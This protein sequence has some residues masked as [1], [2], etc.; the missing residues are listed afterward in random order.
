MTQVS[1]KALAGK[2]GVFGGPHA[3][4]HGRACQQEH[5]RAQAENLP[6]IA[7]G[8]SHVYDLR[9]DQG[10]QKLADDLQDNQDGGE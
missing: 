1:A 2:G 3:A 4:G 10:K 8:D 9:H 7:G 5:L 6:H